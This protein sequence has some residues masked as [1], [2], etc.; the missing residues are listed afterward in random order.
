MTT[1]ELAELFL[2]HLYDL[3]EASPHPNFLFTVN[4]FAPMFGISDRH[5]LQEAM[6]LLGDRGLVINAAMDMMGGISAAITMEGSVFVEEGGMTGIIGRY[7]EDRGAFISSEPFEAPSAPSGLSE[8]SAPFQPPAGQPEA[9]SFSAG[10]AVE[11]IIADMAR[12]LERGAGVGDE[13]RKDAMADLAALKIQLSRSA[14]NARVVEALIDGL[15]RV[16]PIAPLAAA[17]RSIVSGYDA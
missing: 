2:A 3:A 16:G 4:D 15:C 11:A 14:A 9:A 6:D 1:E 12:I 13:E 7:R 17:L 10:G 8:P 5:A